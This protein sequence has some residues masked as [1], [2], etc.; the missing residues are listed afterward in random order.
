L[1]RRL[2]EWAKEE[3]SFIELGCGN[4]NISK[5]LLDAGM[6]GVG[7]DLSDA[8]CKSSA[9]ENRSYID[10]GKYR[11]ENAD[12]FCVS[13]VKVDFILSSH[14]IEH[15][16]DE[17]LS[18]YF[19]KCKTLLKPGGRV[20][21]LVPASMS[22]WGIEDETVGHYRRFESSDFVKIAHDKEL[23]VD[24]IAGLTFPLSNILLGLS[25]Y[26][27]TKSESWKKGLSKDEQ[28]ELSSTGVRQVKYKTV[29]PPYFRFIANETTMYPFHLLQRI[30]KNN[31]NS[32][33]VYC[34]LSQLRC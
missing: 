1:K 29:F 16:P 20:V 7:Y 33:V 31:G 17:T 32:L 21:S 23:H 22:Q 11:V 6:S 9:E 28:T 24:H 4:G 2:K 19:D 14:V 12:F 8:A 34:E 3:M 27:L 10:A 25:N 18:S 26:L 13:D 15:F 5:I 30:F